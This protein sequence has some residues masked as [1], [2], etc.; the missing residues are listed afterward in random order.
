MRSW[1]SQRGLQ[2][3]N[4]KWHGTYACFETDCPRQHPNGFKAKAD[5]EAHISTSHSSPLSVAMTGMVGENTSQQEVRH[6]PHIPFTSQL[7]TRFYK[8][9]FRESSQSPSEISG[10]EIRA[11]SSDS[12]VRAEEFDPRYK[13]CRSSEFRFGRVC[14]LDIFVFWHSFFQ[15]F[16]TIWLEPRGYDGKATFPSNQ[17]FEKLRRFVVMRNLGDHSLCL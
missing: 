5:L 14:S 10:S 8:N 1:T 3:H 7:Q 17:V 16:K 13:R 6:I 12:A 15:I 9:T 4:Q 2:K 11:V